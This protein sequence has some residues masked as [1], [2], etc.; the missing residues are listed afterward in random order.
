MSKM[1]DMLKK[2][3]SKLETI[4]SDLTDMKVTIAKQEENIKLHIYRTEIAEENIE[5]LKTKLEPID[6]HVKYVHGVLR[7]FGAFSLFT[8]IIIGLI[9][10]FKSIAS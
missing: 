4:S 1:D 8:G 10:I 3:D 7:F 9:S 5:I 6:T 2:I